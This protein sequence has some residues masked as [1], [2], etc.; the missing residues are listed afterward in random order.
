MND[1]KDDSARVRDDGARTPASDL[2]ARFKNTLPLWPVD[3]EGRC[4]C[5]QADCRRPGKHP[6]SNA[7]EGHGY[8]IETGAEN[9]IFVVDCDVKAGVDGIEQ[10]RRFLGLKTGEAFPKTFTVATG[11]GGLHFYFKHPSPAGDRV[12]GT[13]PDTA[14]DIKGDKDRED[15]LVYVVG[16][17]SPGY[18]KRKDDP[19]VALKGV[20]DYEVLFDEPIADAPEVLLA[21]LRISGA[22]TREDAFAPKPI[23]PGHHDWDR[24]VDMAIEACKTMP[25]S[26]GDGEG[27]R[28]LMRLCIKLIR[29]FELPEAH[30]LELIDTFFN[31]R[32]TNDKGEHWP[33]SEEEIA[34]KIE[35]ARD[36]S[37][38]PCG[39]A[40][41]EFESVIIRRE[42]VHE[43]AKARLEAGRQ[44]SAAHEYDFEYGKAD[45]KKTTE[46]VTRE[47][48]VNILSGLGHEKWIDVLRFDELRGGVSALRPP[49]KLDAETTTF[50]E[51]D[52]ERVAYWLACEMGKSASPDVILRVVASIARQKPF[53]PLVEYFRSLP[54]S[55]GA[56]DELCALLGA[57]DALSRTYV[58][59]FLLAAVRRAANPGCKSDSILG[60]HGLPDAGKSSFVQAL[61]GE[62]WASESLPKLSD[63]KAV[64]EALASKWGVELAELA[65]MFRVERDTTTAFITRLVDRYRGAYA[66]G[67]AK[68]HPRMCVLIGTVNGSEIYSDVH[69]ADV[70][71]IWVLDVPAT[72]DT[73]RVRA[74]RD[75]IWSE[76]HA[77]T[78]GDVWTGSMLVE[79][80]PHWLVGQEKEEHAARADQYRE[81]DAWQG[82]VERFLAGRP[83][84]LDASNVLVGALGMS[85][86]DITKRETNRMAKVLRAIGCTLRRGVLRDGRKCNVWEM[87][88]E[89]AS[90]PRA[91]AVVTRLAS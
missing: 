12:S 36:R 56:I 32:C 57:G 8:A 58:R 37:S 38:I 17:G 91:R 52:A 60:L 83:E 14:I 46:K 1:K 27:G 24:R 78:V 10:F 51:D 42:G 45:T 41:R 69:G 5:G 85:M 67:A 11:S 34:H 77:A 3:G 20:A 21:W 6:A 66:R 65:E 13:K 31:P 33:W 81:R 4:G 84:V 54:P 35:D 90:V 47:D 80:E 62:E 28:N 70:R 63:T 44:T 48:L 72:I 86:K 79:G 7:P 71:R 61:F 23:S 19:T 25:E 88:K 89:L 30:S 9:G 73:A 43:R 26:K 39:I 2:Q 76:A 55:T 40:P 75:R 53:N 15:G 59:K 29:T 18:V 68:D 16:P 74:L 64:G 87:P 22:G 49:I 82:D 50:S